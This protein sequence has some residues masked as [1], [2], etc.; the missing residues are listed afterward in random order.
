VSAVPEL[1]VREAEVADAGAVGQLLHDFNSEFDV[2]TPGPSV[3]AERVRALLAAG[4]MT[5]LLGGAG[6]DGLAVLR[7]CPAVM[8]EGLECYLEH[9]R[10]PG[11]SRPRAGTG[12]DG[13]GSERRAA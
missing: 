8:M 10:G 12:A 1:A 11:A 6:P 7:F 4:E 13:D 3:V 2:P 9:L 5:I